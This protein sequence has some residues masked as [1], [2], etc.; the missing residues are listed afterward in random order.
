MSELYSDVDPFVIF[1][2][3]K[4]CELGLLP[5]V[6]WRFP[7]YENSHLGAEML[8]S[9][10]NND[11]F[12]LCEMIISMSNA[13]LWFLLLNDI[14]KIDFDNNVKKMA[15]FD[16]T[17][18]FFLYDLVREGRIKILK[19]AHENNCPVDGIMCET[20]AR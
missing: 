2:P 4:Y 10:F 11:H 5:V 7:F 19:Y 8:S 20:T 14:E 3:S 6:A 1:D 18:P 15:T 17:D 9:A 12:Q 13:S 16:Y